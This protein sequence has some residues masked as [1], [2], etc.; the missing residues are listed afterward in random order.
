M[1]PKQNKALEFALRLITKTDKTEAE[2]LNRLYKKGFSEEEIKETIEY[3]K[4]KGFINDLKFIQKAEKIAEDRFLG[5]IGLKS[6]FIRRGIDRDLIQNI[7]EIDELSIAMRLIQRKSHFFKDISPDKKKAKIT[8]FLLRRG[9]SWDTINECLKMSEKIFE[10][11][12]SL[13]NKH[14]KEV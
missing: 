14:L 5:M 1:K 10:D 2:I 3:L 6:Y 11:K 9:F 13:Q 4:N 8:G 7:P 12:E